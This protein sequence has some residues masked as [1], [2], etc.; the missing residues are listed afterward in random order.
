MPF[1]IKWFLERHKNSCRFTSRTTACGG[2]TSAMVCVG[3]F[4]VRPLFCLNVW[5]TYALNGAFSSNIVLWRRV[6]DQTTHPGYSPDVWLNKCWGEVC[7]STSVTLQRNDGGEATERTMLNL[8]E[9]PSDAT[10]NQ[11]YTLMSQTE[12]H[13]TERITNKPTDYWTRYQSGG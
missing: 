1:S 11:C 8:M 6:K 2:Y 13:G 10:F 4:L 3:P 9:S 12:R 5:K 7:I